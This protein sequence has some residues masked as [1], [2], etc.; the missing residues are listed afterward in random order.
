MDYRMLCVV[1]LSFLA[2][3]NSEQ[4]KF[5][6]CGKYSLMFIYLTNLIIC[7]VFLPCFFFFQSLHFLTGS[8]DGHVVEVDIQPCSQQPCQLHKGQSYTVNVTFSSS[9]WLYAS[10]SSL[11]KSDL[12]LGKQQLVCISHR[13]CE[14]DQ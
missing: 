10:S 12:N 9:E 3:T 11:N 4:V 13:C 1:L 6:D 2:Y 7:I 5:V 8:V 14:S